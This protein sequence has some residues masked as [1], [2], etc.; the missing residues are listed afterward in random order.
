MLDDALKSGRCTSPRTLHELGKL[1]D[2]DAA[3]VQSL[4][5][6]GA[7]IT[8]ATVSG[9]RSTQRASP[10]T[11]PSASAPAPAY[12]INQAVAACDR[13]ERAL[14]R[15]DASDPS[16]GAHPEVNALLTRV[17][18]IA[19]RWRQGSDRQT[20]SQVER[21]AHGEWSEWDERGWMAG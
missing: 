3:Q 4:L 13:L 20:P 5:A 19:E 7:E 14:E 21:W 8:R 10:T 9:L 11:S 2:Q 1:H 18:G 12:L 15:L 17:A 6:S 16:M